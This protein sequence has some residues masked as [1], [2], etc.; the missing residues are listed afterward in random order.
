VPLTIVGAILAPLLLELP[1][2]PPAI[3]NSLGSGIG[4]AE[5]EAIPSE[6]YLIV[7]QDIQPKSRETTEIDIGRLLE[8]VREMPD[9]SRCRWGVLDW[10]DP[11]FQAIES[12]SDPNRRLRCV[13]ELCRAI[14]ALK[15][16]FPT[17]RWTVWGA[18][19]LPYWIDGKAWDA[20][21]EDSRSRAIEGALARWQPVMECCDWLMPWV[22]VV[23]NRDKPSRQEADRSA[24]RHVAWVNA[25]VR[26]CRE[27]IRRT[28]RMVP[29]IPC[30]CPFVAPN[31]GN[32]PGIPLSTEEFLELQARP[33]FD[34]GA[35]GLAIWSALDWW[36][37][38][39]FADYSGK[40]RSDVLAAQASSRESLIRAFGPIDW[41][42]AEERF[43][44]AREASNLVLL[45]LRAA[46]PLWRPRQRG[47]GGR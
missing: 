45:D 19:E 39:A 36:L 7:Y 10:E 31:N 2:S 29:V 35:N 9:A 33:V 43:R 38:S 11:H 24:Q 32:K 26:L 4:T 44:V 12:P 23:E 16:E 21:G 34:A 27:H 40:T 5:A 25:K 1:C 46:I 47:P 13:T 37:P 15:A 8:V 3:Y 42:N 14:S 30:V 20:A 6:Q 41:M 22:Y 28:G 17:I 18:P